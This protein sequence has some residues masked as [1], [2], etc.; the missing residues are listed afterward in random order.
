MQNILIDLMLLDM[1]MICSEAYSEQFAKELIQINL[2][3]KIK[4][5]SEQIITAR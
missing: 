4:S 5:D 2:F 3:K 1:H